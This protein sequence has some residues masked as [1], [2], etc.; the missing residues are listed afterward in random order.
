MLREELRFFPEQTP[1][2]R[3]GEEIPKRANA[4]KLR[5]L[6]PAWAPALFFYIILPPQ[7][8]LVG[9]GLLLR[10]CFCALSPQEGELR[11]G[12]G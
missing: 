8:S 11:A 12:P 1:W 9:V 3:Q 2:A 10:D 6:T 7:K 5:E 4:G